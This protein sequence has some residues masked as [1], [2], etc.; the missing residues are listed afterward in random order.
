MATVLEKDAA[1]IETKRGTCPICGVGCYVEAKIAGNKAISI[2]PDRT[3]GFPADCPRAGQAIDYHDHRERLNYPLKRVGKR[4]EGKWERI[5]WDQALD[6]IAE[7][8]AAIREKHGPEAVQTMGGSYKGAGDASCWRWS[9]LWGTPNILYQGKNCGEAELL[10]EWAVYGD[11]SCIGNQPV[12]G[13]TKCVILWGVG[14]AMSLISQ[15]KN[16]KAFR[17]AGGKLIVIDPR[18]TDLTEMA[19]IWLQ[20]RPGA[21]GAL[22]YGLLNVIIAEKLYDADFVRDWCTGFD[23]LAAKVKD[24]T[25]ERVSEITWIPAEQIVEAARM[26]ATSKPA[27]IPFGL[28][29]AELGKATTSAVFGKTY[30][31]AITGNLDIE[32]GSK[33]ADEPTSTRFIDEMH[34]DTLI[35][36]PVRT[37]D[38]ISANRW[39]IAS[40]RGLK[41]YRKAMAKVHPKGIGPTIYNMV[42]APGAIPE[43]ILEG[44]P[45]PIK[46]WIL[47]A[48]NPLVALGDAKKLHEAMMSD[49]LELSVNM[50]HWMTPCGALA[51]YVLPATDGLERPLLSNMWGFGDAHSASRRIVEPLYERRDDYQLW[52]ELGNR[53]GQ[54][55]MW[56]DTMEEWFDDILEPTGKSHA[57]LADQ[58][59]PW[60]MAPPS[61]RRYEKTGFATAS[62]K[63]ELSS[64]LLESLGYPPIPD[65]EEPTW[66]PQ[67]SPELFEKFPMILTTGNSLKWYYRSQHKHLEKMRRQHPYAQAT[68]HPDTAAELG[69]EH[70]QMVWIETPMGKVKQVAKL[71]P[72]MHPRVVHADSHMWY[73]EREAEGDAHFGVWESNINAI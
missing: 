25:P 29:T 73:P 6:E 43:A 7:K 53:L 35:N 59:V 33:F 30:L 41:A 22:A 51:D 31:R 9:N 24:Y 58:D 72:G 19:D 23:D 11:Q 28:G 44:K 62:G 54:E 15:R 61:Y 67:S 3:A 10:S 40:V 56:P 38:N 71:D 8:L 55:G 49:E 63:V 2:R 69:I 17:D 48:G 12:P 1:A 57:E 5:S 60:L 16:L 52:R 42:V 20:I 68:L 39:P 32:G 36:H 50:D 34:W 66:S 47:Q 46:A 65:Y 26:F 14:G 70:D 37:R 27:H 21:D 18:S 45:Y 4:G 13:V 64:A